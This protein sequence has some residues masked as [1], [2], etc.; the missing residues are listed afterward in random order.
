MGESI[1]GI[2]PRC[3]C[4]GNYNQVSVVGLQSLVPFRG[5]LGDLI[6][7]RWEVWYSARLHIRVTVG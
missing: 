5:R 7:T 3:Q 4:I 1:A 2:S 6:E